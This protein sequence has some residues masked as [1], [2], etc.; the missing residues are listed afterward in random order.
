MMSQV[1]YKIFNGSYIFEYNI[2]YH[3]LKNYDIGIYCN[4]DVVVYMDSSNLSDFFD[5]FG[6][7]VTLPSLLITY[8][9][10]SYF[11]EYVI[12]ERI[13]TKFSEIKKIIKL[14]HYSLF[15]AKLDIIIFKN[16]EH[17][18]ILKDKY[19]VSRTFSY[20]E[21]AL[22]NKVD[23]LENGDCYVFLIDVTN[24]KLIDIYYDVTNKKRM[25]KSKYNIFYKGKNANIRF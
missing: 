12:Q 16:K 20:S 19:Q 1:K 11:V 14:P 22:F 24:N 10:F 8:N 4:D 21:K 9:D 23:E 6:N 17:K 3:N 2:N 5:G 25:T 13:K 15:F 7:M 18:L